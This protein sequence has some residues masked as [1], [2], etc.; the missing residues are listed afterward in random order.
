MSKL[1]LP[2]PPEDLR[3]LDPQILEYDQALW[4]VHRTTSAYPAAWNGMRYFGPLRDMRFDPHPAGPPRMSAEGVLYAAGDIATALAEVY[5]RTRIID[6]ITGT[7]HLS[8]WRPTR[9]LR[10]LDLTADWPIRAGASHAINS[11]RKDHCRAWARAIRTAW[12]HLDGLAHDAITGQTGI[13]LFLPAANSLPAAPDTSRPLGDPATLRAV[14]PA[15]H[16]IN[17]RVT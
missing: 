7:P 9:R 17:Y 6:T 10:L 2:P 15:A 8:G 1:P 16:H 12:P 4:R 11:G 13:T 14:Y 5:Q 3:N